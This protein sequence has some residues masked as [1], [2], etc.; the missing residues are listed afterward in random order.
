MKI[1]ERSD[2]Y[3][4]AA[5]DRHGLVRIDYNSEMLLKD[6]DCELVGLTKVKQLDDGKWVAE[7]GQ[8]CGIDDVT[9]IDYIFVRKPEHQSIGIIE[10]LTN[11]EQFLENCPERAMIECY[12]CGR[13]VHWL[14]L[15]LQSESEF[16]RLVETVE[17]MSRNYCGC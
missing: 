3:F 11:L 13:R 16:D 6:K 1:D 14:D 7:R 5:W 4:T 9:I 15:N 10:I 8:A 17:L 2:E 12:D